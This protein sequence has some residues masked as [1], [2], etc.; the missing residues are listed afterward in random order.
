MD[1]IL[2]VI[3]ETPVSIHGARFVEAECFTISDKKKERKIL[4]M[5]KE[6]WQGLK[7]RLWKN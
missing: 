4:T 6:E 2:Q 7:R 1:T 5:P 3:S